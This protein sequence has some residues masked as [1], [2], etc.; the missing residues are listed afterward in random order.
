LSLVHRSYPDEDDEDEA[1]K[2]NA[3]DEDGDDQDDFSKRKIFSTVVLLQR[4]ESEGEQRF[5]SQRRLTAREL[6]T[7]TASSKLKEKSEKLMEMRQKAAQVEQELQFNR[8]LEVETKR[9]QK[10]RVKL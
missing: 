1:D 2:E 7:K 5:Y 10:A 8:Q 9:L 4:L 3:D 6:R